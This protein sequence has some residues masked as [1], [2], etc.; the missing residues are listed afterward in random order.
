MPAL[1]LQQKRVQIPEVLP[2]Q[3]LLYS[4]KGNL[5]EVMCKPKIMAIKSMTLQKIE[6]MQK[7]ASKGATEDTKEAPQRP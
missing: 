3:G 5:S 1:S 7:E 4:E 6:S 2:K